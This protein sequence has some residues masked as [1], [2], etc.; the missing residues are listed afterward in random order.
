MIRFPPGI[1][2]RTVERRGEIEQERNLYIRLHCSSGV[3]KSPLLFS[4]NSRTVSP[5]GIPHII[6]TGYIDFSTEVQNNHYG[7]TNST[8]RAVKFFAESINSDGSDLLHHKTVVILIAAV[9]H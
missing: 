6:C 4:G 5:R 8:D 2:H 7:V 1:K 9:K 3:R